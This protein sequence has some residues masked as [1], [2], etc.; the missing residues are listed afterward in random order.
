MRAFLALLSVLALSAAV[1]QVAPTLH[2]A[3]DAQPTRL[4]LKNL[5]WDTSQPLPALPKHGTLSN[6]EAADAGYWVV[7]AAPSNRAQ[8]EDWVSANG[9]Q[10]FDYVPHHAFEARIPASALSALRAQESCQEILAVHPFLKVSPDTGHFGTVMDQPDG[11]MALSVELWPDADLATV[12]E[13]VTEWGAVVL[14]EAVTERYTRLDLRVAPLQVAALARI[15]EIRWLEESVQPVLRNDKT[16]WVVQTNRN[17]DMKIWNKGLSGENVIIGHIDGRIQEGSCF[18]DDP[19]GAAVG[20]NHRK[21][22]YMSTSGSGESHGTHTAGSAAGNRTPVDGQWKYNGVA[23]GARIAHLRNNEVNSSNFLSK[24]TVLARKGATVFTNSWGNDGTTQYNNW[25]RDIDAMSHDYEPSV[26]CFAET[27]GSNLKNPENAKSCVA[28]AAAD[29]NNPDQKGSG[30]RGPT[31]DGRAKPEVMAPG[32]SLYSAKNSNSCSTKTM[33]GT[34]MACPIVAGG[35]ALA[36]EYFEKGFY[37]TGAAN[38]AD[39]FTPSGSLLRGL[40]ANSTTD[41]LDM[42]GWP[43]YS[44]GWGRILLENTMSFAGEAGG[45]W[46]MDQWHING[47]QT[48]QTQTWQFDVPASMQRLAV[49]MAFADEPASAFASYAPV[50]DLNLVLI[51]PNGDEYHGNLLRLSTGEWI[52]NTPKH[53]PKN[54]MEQIRLNQPAAGTWTVSVTGKDVPRGPQGFALLAAWRE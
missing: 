13:K 40:L 26:I 44:E 12:Y 3:P 48:G 47:V 15:P 39:G 32:C 8:L 1:S 22:V 54:S 42:G 45:L 51:A 25:C 7:Q 38:S 43:S 14:E 27:N 29:R 41:M 24:L 53:D 19:T 46:V 37:P 31:S 28:V 18:F 36:K 49:T 30:G 5:D 23:F 35:A 10:V 6:Q 11:S 50:N 33:C 52:V 21:L 4:L 16:V 2:S 20:P 34:S 17:N 9:G